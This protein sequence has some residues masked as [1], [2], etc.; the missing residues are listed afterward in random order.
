MPADDAVASWD[1][2]AE[3][4]DLPA[5]HGLRDDSV[6]DVWRDLLLGLLP[7]PPASVAEMG[8]GTGTLSVLLADEGYQVDGVD[9]SPEMLRR[10]ELKAAGR[11]SV[12]LRL[13]DAAVPPLPEAA[14]DVVLSRHVLWAMP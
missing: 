4:Y 1:A 10:A 3:D 11:S 14:Y 12:R 9:F 8:C 5:D 6:R 13:G 7:D 2:E